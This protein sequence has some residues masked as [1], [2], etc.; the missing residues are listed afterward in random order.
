MT[1]KPQKWLSVKI[2]EVFFSLGSQL[3]SQPAPS[4]SQRRT[5]ENYNQIKD[6]INGTI[7][8]QL[9]KTVSPLENALIRVEI[10]Q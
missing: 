9:E 2:R 4:T 5:K 3:N 6:K 7:L 1:L 8:L 10:P